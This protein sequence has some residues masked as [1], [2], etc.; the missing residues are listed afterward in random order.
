MPEMFGVKVH[1]KVTFSDGW[2]SSLAYLGEITK[3]SQ[4]S[5]I[6]GDDDFHPG[7]WCQSR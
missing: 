1:L 6:F 3:L 4:F 2:H 5:Q 7:N